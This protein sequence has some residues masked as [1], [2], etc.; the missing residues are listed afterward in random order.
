MSE[1]DLGKSLLHL[2]AAALSAVPDARQQTWNILARD[3]G[4]VRLLTGIT[5]LVWLFAA[6]L[7]VGGLVGFGMIIPKQEKL[8]RD[9]EDGKLTPAQRDDIQR[10]LLVGFQK[11]TLLIA[12]S[13]AV[14]SLTVVCT[15]LLILATRRATLRHVNASLVE[16]SEQLKQ[17][18]A[19]P[20]P[21]TTGIAP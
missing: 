13:V 20:P 9:L 5:A 19:T 1:K 21:S 3:R 12:F 2:D 18:R 6:L 4:R 14:M 10:T 17:L 16:I 8:M 11:G 7:V 15:I